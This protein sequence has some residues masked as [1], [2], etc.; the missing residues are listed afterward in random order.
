MDPERSEKRLAAVAMLFRCLMWFPVWMLL[1]SFQWQGVENL[2]PCTGL[3]LGASYLTAIWAR[4][5]KLHFG[6]VYPMRGRMMSL[7][8]LVP[9]I[10]GT[11]Y[12]LQ[13]M[14]G[15]MVYSVL[16]AGV[17]M[18]VLCATAHKPAE[19]LYAAPVYGAYLVL[20]VCALL[21]LML[22]GLPVPMTLVLILTGVQ[23][24]G[25][26]VLRNQFMLRRLVNRRSNRE[27]DVPRDIRRMNLAL[28]GMIFLILIGGLL[29]RKPLGEL[30][31]LMETVAVLAVRLVLTVFYKAVNLFDGEPTGYSEAETV[32]PAELMQPADGKLSPLWM[33]L[34]IPVLLAAFRVW[35][36]FLSEW[37]YDL[38]MALGR[39]IRRL[40]GKPEPA[41]RV[42]AVTENAAY[43][44]TETRTEK[45]PSARQ[46]R[47]TWR[48]E[49]RA[50]ERLPDSAEKFY[51][52]YQLLLRAPAWQGEPPRASETVREIREHWK[53]LCCGSL[54]AV[55]DD[56][57]AHRYAEQTLPQQ[58]LADI[59]AALAAAGGK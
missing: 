28:T 38:R 44:D 50:W 23:S 39:M 7:L 13:R 46:E 42:L 31:R 29:L 43:T 4:I 58:A 5:W 36:V 52:G 22:A 55:T 57:H 18:T 45:K 33:L 6:T 1:L 32:N 8:L 41:E 37:F 21:F 35:Q 48:K 30:I 34:W 10:C 2:L 20:T 14:T 49:F 53:S 16:L 24:A 27:T 17:T 51:A 11:V 54:D 25:F 19:T 15:D 12:L 59:S 47:R 9:A 56:F 3:L 26:F 40:R